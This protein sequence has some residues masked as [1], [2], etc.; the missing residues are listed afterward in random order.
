ME[1]NGLAYGSGNVNTVD[2][3]ANETDDDD[4]ERPTYKPYYYQKPAVP[5]H[6]PI[7]TVMATTTTKSRAAEKLEDF[8]GYNYPKPPNPM[9]YPEQPAKT[10]TQRND[11]PGASARSIMFKN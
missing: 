11:L 4:D 7:K 8:A 3:S 9:M 2:D 1:V 6:P 5:F 10:T